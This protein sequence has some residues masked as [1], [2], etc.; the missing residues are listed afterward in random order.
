V[1]PKAASEAMVFDRES[2]EKRGWQT[3]LQTQEMAYVFVE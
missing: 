3:M 2:V 1:L